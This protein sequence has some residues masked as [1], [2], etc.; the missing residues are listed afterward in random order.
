MSTP[1]PSPRFANGYFFISKP[2][3]SPVQPRK[4]AQ[5]SERERKQR[6]VSESVSQSVSQSASPSDAA[7][8]RKAKVDATPDA[9]SRK[10][11]YIFVLHSTYATSLHPSLFFFVEFT[12]PSRFFL[13]CNYCRPLPLSLS[14]SLSLSQLSPFPIDRC[15]NSTTNLGA[16][17]GA[18][19]K[20]AD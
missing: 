3:P 1:H 2:K 15:G 8:S 9:K 7:Q 4:A 17:L 13:P 12:P 16:Q 18:W 6:R 14:L 10:P 20:K 11:A 19:S 5:S